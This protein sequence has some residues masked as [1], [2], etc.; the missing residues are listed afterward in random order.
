MKIQKEIKNK[1][2]DETESLVALKERQDE[3]IQ[4][5]NAAVEAEDYDKAA[6]LEE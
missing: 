1:I 4:K 5:Q 3:S 6:E 2:M